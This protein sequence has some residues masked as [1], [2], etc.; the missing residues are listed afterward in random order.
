MEACP[1]VLHETGMHRDVVLCCSLGNSLPKLNSVPPE[2]LEKA[3]H[4]ESKHIILSVHLVFSGCLNRCAAH[5]AHL[6]VLLLLEV[7]S[8][9]R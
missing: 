6:Q 5:I 7:L 1:T 9:E 2:E 8:T 3:L 4:P